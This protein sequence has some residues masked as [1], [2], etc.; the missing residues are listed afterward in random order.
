MLSNPSYLCKTR[1]NAL[2]RLLHFCHFKRYP[3]RSVILQ[4]G[5]SGDALRII[6]EGAVTISVEDGIENKEIVLAYLNRGDFVGEAGVFLGEAR[7]SVV[8]KTREACQIAEISY[9]RLH[10]LLQAELALHATD[11]LYMLG[12]QL[13]NRLLQTSRKVSN[14]AFLDVTGRIVHTLIDLC[15]QPEAMSHPDGMQIRITR[16]EIGRLVGCSREM[17][18]RMLKELENRGLIAVKGKTIVVFGTR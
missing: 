13:S 8:V 1:D 7:R 12:V 11:I 6:L 2:E 5:D 16:Q 18:G 15:K 3:S 10:Q 4:P 17:A 9:Q 14:L